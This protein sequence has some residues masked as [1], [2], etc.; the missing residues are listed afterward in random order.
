VTPTAPPAG[1]IV[2]IITDAAKRYNQSPEAMIAVARCESNLD[3]NAYNRSSGA[4]GL[5][6]FLPGTWRTTPYASANIFDP[7]ASA[8]AA[9]WM[10]SV[11]RR[12]E[13]V[14]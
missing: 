14:C 2:A 10:W 8:N 1:T 4:S 12:G 3:P 9:A 7:V 5:F 13:W 6:Q 11:G